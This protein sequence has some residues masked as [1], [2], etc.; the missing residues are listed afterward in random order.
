VVKIS[1]IKLQSQKNSKKENQPIRVENYDELKKIVWQDIQQGIN[2]RDILQKK[3]SINGEIIGLNPAKVKKI[4]EESTN[5]KSSTEPTQVKLFK[6]FKKNVSPIDA[7]I[8]TKCSYE[9]LKAG[10]KEYLEF[11]NKTT[12]PVWFKN[13]ILRL[14]RKVSPDVNDF[15]NILQILEKTVDD[16]LTYRIFKYPCYRCRKPMLILGPE[17]PDI[18]AF[19]IRERWR[20]DICP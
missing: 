3:F 17:W 11:E 10:Y 15:E 16:A 20:H 2:Q 4:K 5:S 18:K 12:V 19:L 14:L 7:L 13:E 8:N 6:L 9:E 1:R